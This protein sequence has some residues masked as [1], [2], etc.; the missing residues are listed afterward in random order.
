MSVG[1]LWDE[2]WTEEDLK[3]V[4][5]S[6]GIADIEPWMERA[7]LK[8]WE[9]YKEIH[10]YYEQRYVGSLLWK[11]RALLSV[12]SLNIDGG[13]HMVYWDGTRIWDPNE[14]LEG[15]QHFKFISSCKISRVVIF[16]D[17]QK[18]S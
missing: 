16:S 10:V 18:D 2:L 5:E 17:D 8:Q 1:K 6:R 4:I 14:G 7:G 13:S 9:D 15:K 3:K 12:D 11:R